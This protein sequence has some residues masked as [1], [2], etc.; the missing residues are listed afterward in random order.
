MAIPWLQDRKNRHR[1][2]VIIG[3]VGVA[4][5]L[6]MFL[7][8]FGFSAVENVLFLFGV[9]LLYCVIL[10][11]F[12]PRG[13]ALALVVVG[14]IVASVYSYMLLRVNAY[15]V[16]LFLQVIILVAA[17]LASGYLCFRSAVKKTGK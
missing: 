15:I 7:P 6:G 13:G 10:E 3:F 14:I 2:G 9:P 1:A 8:F 16:L 12:F 5:F 11:W 4:A 17:V